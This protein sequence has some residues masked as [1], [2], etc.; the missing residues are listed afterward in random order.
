[1]HL[2][3]WLTC[4]LISQPICL[5]SIITGLL[6]TKPL[7]DDEDATDEDDASDDHPGL[8]VCGVSD[9]WCNKMI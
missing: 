9:P 6:T 1:M 7:T 8:S 3:S 5:Y 4:H 2:L